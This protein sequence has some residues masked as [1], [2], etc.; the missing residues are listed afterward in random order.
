MKKKIISFPVGDGINSE[1]AGW[2]FGGSTVENFDK[3]IKNSIPL[4]TEGHSLCCKLSEFFIQNDSTC[5][6]L[7][8]STGT[9]INQLKEHN[10][11]KTN[12]NWTGIDRE[13]DMISKARENYPKIEFIASNLEDIELEKSNLIISYYTLQFT[14]V[15]NRLNICKKIYESLDKG[16]ALIIFEKVRANS[17]KTQ[18]YFNQTYF[19]FKLE[20]GYTEKEVINK[21]LALK[22]VLEPLSSEENVQMFK[23]AGFKE[24]NS[25]MKWLC[26]QGWLCI[27]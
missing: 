27:K 5:Y 15:K 25:V 16:G 12:T 22:S 19:D 1:N 2:T 26:F 8:T 13:K 17:A 6:E 24:I 18:D 11:N 20:Q 3:Q 7:G 14:K 21:S 23:S 9:L 10:K 4:Y